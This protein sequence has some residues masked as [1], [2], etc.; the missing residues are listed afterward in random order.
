MRIFSK[1]TGEHPC[2]SVIS[3]KLQSNFIEITLCH[4][5][6]PVNL[7]H[8]FRKTSLK[9]TSG[10]LLRSILTLVEK[11]LSSV[12]TNRSQALIMIGQDRLL[13]IEKGAVQEQSLVGYHNLMFHHH[14]RTLSIQTRHFLVKRQNSNHFIT[15]IRKS[16]YLICLTLLSLGEGEVHLC[17]QQM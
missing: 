5:C 8:I 7:Q 1:F 13:T 6:S 4:G 12:H 15:D 14:K 11:E 17:S 9:D 10:R 16:K 2:R 3:I